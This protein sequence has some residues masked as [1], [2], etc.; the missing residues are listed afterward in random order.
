M[1]RAKVL[2][3]FAIIPCLRRMHWRDMFKKR[4]PSAL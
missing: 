2:L 1:R 3:K 4:D